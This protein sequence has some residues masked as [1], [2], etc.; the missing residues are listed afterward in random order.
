MYISNGIDDVKYIKFGLW[1][2]KEG[3]FATYNLYSIVICILGIFTITL[4]VVFIV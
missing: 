3:E 1:S 2:I 4:L